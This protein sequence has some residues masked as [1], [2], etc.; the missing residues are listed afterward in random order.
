MCLPGFGD[1]VQDQ[2]GVI[3][4]RIASRPDSLLGQI[5]LLQQLALLREQPHQL[6]DRRQALYN[7]NKQVILVHCRAFDGSAEAAR[8][9]DYFSFRK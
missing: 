7:S 3:G 6:A 5:H 1:L 4:L 2:V 8:C 9:L